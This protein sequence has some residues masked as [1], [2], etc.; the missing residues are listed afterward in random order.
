[1]ILGSI[2]T[3]RE[4][5]VFVEAAV[6]NKTNV[7]KYYAHMFHRSLWDYQDD[8]KKANSNKDPTQ[9]TL[10]IHRYCTNSCILR[11]WPYWKEHNKWVKTKNTCIHPQSR[12]WVQCSYPSS[13]PAH[14]HSTTLIFEKNYK[15]NNTLETIVE[16]SYLPYLSLW[17]FVSVRKK[18]WLMPNSMLH[19]GNL[20]F[21]SKSF[22]Y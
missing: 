7:H 6:F 9:T 11:V 2:K 19:V 22:L 5:L 3:I 4:N 16:L 13:I 10:P 21:G 17:F 1:M 14:V 8:I 20:Y 12:I 18:I 15:S